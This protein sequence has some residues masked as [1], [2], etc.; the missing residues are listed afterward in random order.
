M[1]RALPEPAK[2]AALPTVLL[3]NSP[4]DPVVPP[5]PIHESWESHS[6]TTFSLPIIPMRTRAE[7]KAGKA[8]GPG[9][10]LGVVVERLV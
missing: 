3:S 9:G 1:S 2:Q 5:T 7:L 6:K 8:P 10:S 4:H